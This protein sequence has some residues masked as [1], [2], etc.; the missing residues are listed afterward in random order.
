MSTTY[1][2]TGANRGIGLELATQL[3]QAG[4]TVIATARSPKDSPELANLQKTYPKLCSVFQLD[5]TSEESVK[6]LQHELE[7]L[8]K[9]DVLIN[10]AG[11]M[12]DSDGGL[13]DLSVADLQNS[14]VT[15]TLGPIRVTQALLGLLQESSKPIVVNIT[16]MMGSI[17]DNTSGG[18]Y[19][20][21]MSKAALNMFAKGLSL[22][23]PE[24]TVLNL[25][26]GWV[27]TDMGGSDAQIS[28]AESAK[29][30]LKV[31]QSADK[32]KSGHFYNFKGQE[33]PW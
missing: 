25:H 32:Q 3:L 15:N 33:L 26:P 12:L 11:V 28:T 2:I 20:Y 13:K 18:S 31:I 7:K 10:N 4:E 17:T 21:R 27:Q 8:A 23:H 5:V 6:S 1:L 30:L 22:E 9:I 19:G 14:F 24:L 29:G 16:S